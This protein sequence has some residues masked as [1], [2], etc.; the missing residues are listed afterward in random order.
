VTGGQIV[1]VFEGRFRSGHL[2]EDVQRNDLELGTEGIED[3]LH[4]LDRAP[5]ANVK[6]EEV[7]TLRV[8]ARELP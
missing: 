1:R 6:E 4:V 2:K 7:W 5:L 3:A 8:E